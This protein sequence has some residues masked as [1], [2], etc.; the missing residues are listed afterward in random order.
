M[1]D[2]SQLEAELSALSPQELEAKRR[3]IV[4]S[5]NG[6]FNSLSTDDLTQLA[7][8]TAILRRRTVGPPKAPREKKAAPTV[9]SL[10]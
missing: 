9:D 10:F 7:F 4:T 6:D 1:A 5:A 8:I 3:V 2:S